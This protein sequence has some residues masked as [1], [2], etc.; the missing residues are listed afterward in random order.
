VGKK[1]VLVPYNSNR[2][3][4]VKDADII[5]G[6][7]LNPDHVRWELHRV[8]VVEAKLK[9]GQRHQAPRSLYYLDEDTWG[10]VLGD[11]WDAQGQLWK[12]L[13]TMS[14]VMPDV[15]GTVQQ[16]FGYYDMLSGAAYVANVLND[17]PFQHRATKRW[18]EDS[19]T[20]DGLAARG[21]R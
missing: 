8:W 12:T 3:L 18:P 11:R 9:E 19:F 4:Q 1:E 16:T 15:P 5:K 7:H 10:A 17:K 13:W 14:Y 2:L 21:V 6:Q 20:G